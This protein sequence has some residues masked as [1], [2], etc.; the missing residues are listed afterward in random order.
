MS[1]E[2]DD[3]VLLHGRHWQHAQQT[4]RNA[5]LL[6]QLLLRDLAALLE[7]HHVE[8]HEVLLEHEGREEGL[9]RAGHTYLVAVRALQGIVLRRKFD[10]VHWLVQV[11]RQV[12][13]VEGLRLIDHEELAETRHERLVVLLAH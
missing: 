4:Q 7:V 6:V 5:V 3:L 2:I 11:L 9:I 13:D 1:S 10:L 12:V 8:L